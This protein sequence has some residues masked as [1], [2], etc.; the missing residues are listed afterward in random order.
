MKQPVELYPDFSQLSERL[1]EIEKMVK[2]F[3]LDTDDSSKVDQSVTLK[4]S[5]K[6]KALFINHSSNKVNQNG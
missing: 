2:R 4:L 6:R 3:N 5:R 1:E